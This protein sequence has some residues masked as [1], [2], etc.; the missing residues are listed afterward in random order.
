MRLDRV[1]A[2]SRAIWPTRTDRRFRRCAVAVVLGASLVGG[3]AACDPVP[4]TNGAIAL[5]EGTNGSLE[6]TLCKSFTASL[7]YA[8]YRTSGAADWHTFM[9]ARGKLRVT[10]GDSYTTSSRIHGLRV[11]TWTNPKLDP[12]AEIHLAIDAGSTKSTG[13]AMDWVVPNQGLSSKQWWRT[14]GKFYSSACG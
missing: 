5:R 1:R 13:V 6:V 8:Q 10:S 12:G 7:F 4:Q 3:L 14:N 2:I 9:F 11:Q